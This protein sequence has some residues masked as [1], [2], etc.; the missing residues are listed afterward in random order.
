MCVQLLE[1]AS[2]ACN[3]RSCFP[4][5]TT[6]EQYKTTN[7]EGRIQAEQDMLLA[8]CFQADVSAEVIH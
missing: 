2:V 5:V 4:T 6:K 8:V 1:V 7:C 3:F